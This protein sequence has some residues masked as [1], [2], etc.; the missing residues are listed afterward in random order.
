MHNKKPIISCDMDDTLSKDFCQKWLEYYAFD[1]GHKLTVDMVQE[2]DLTKY[3][4]PEYKNKIYDYLKNKQISNVIFKS[5]TPSDNAQEVTK[6]LQEHFELYIVTATNPY[7]LPS[8]AAWLERYFPHISL[9]RLVVLSSKNLFS[10]DYLIDDRWTTI[11]DF[12][13]KGI[14]YT[15]NWNKSAK[16][17]TRVNNWL[18]I[19]SYFEQIIS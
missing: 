12:P 4:L 14:L 8:K 9:D 15:Q 3:V 10:A 1:S 13:G 19:K 11:R 7:N 16:P 18:D 17:K 5:C 2:W 6:W